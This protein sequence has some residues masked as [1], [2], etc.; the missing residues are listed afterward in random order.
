MSGFLVRQRGQ[1]D[2][3][4][5][6]T[7]DVLLV[8][9]QTIVDEVEFAIGSL[10]RAVAVGQVV[11]DQLDELLLPALGLFRE[12]FLHQWLD[13]RDLKRWSE[14]TA[15]AIEPSM[16]CTSADFD[17]HAKVGIFCTVRVLAALTRSFSSSKYLMVSSSFWAYDL[18][19]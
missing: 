4:N 12:G 18:G 8:L 2:K 13:A 9:V 1:R 19:A 6:L 5:G 10:R 11:D 15:R 16:P 3:W 7:V 17:T 14:P